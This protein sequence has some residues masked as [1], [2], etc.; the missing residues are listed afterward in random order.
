[1]GDNIFRTRKI[2]ILG[3]KPYRKLQQIKRLDFTEKLMK[4]GLTDTSILLHDFG[5]SY[6]DFLYMQEIEM[7]GNGTTGKSN[8]LEKYFQNPL[9]EVRHWRIIYKEQE[10][11]ARYPES[12]ERICYDKCDLGYP[13]LGCNRRHYAWHT[14]DYRQQNR[15]S[16]RLRSQYSISGH[17]DNSLYTRIREEGSKDVEKGA[18][19]LYTDIE[20]G[21]V[22]AKIKT[23]T[24]RFEGMFLWQPMK[25]GL[26]SFVPDESKEPFW[27][28]DSGFEKYGG[29]SD[30]TKKV[31][32]IYGWDVYELTDAENKKYWREGKGHYPDKT[33]CV[34]EEGENF[35]TASPIFHPRTL[36]RATDY[37]RQ[38]A[39]KPVSMLLT[40]EQLKAL[41]E[42][43]WVWIEVLEPFPC[44]E[45]VSA[46]YRKGYDYSHGRSFCCG[47]PGMSFLFDYSSYNDAW[48]AY[49]CQP[50]E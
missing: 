36:Q 28:D 4:Q 20:T 8:F 1:M 43:E 15:E 29:M 10:I 31:K 19:N 40:V 14:V 50:K 49:S 47:Y 34:F 5:F 30:A 13:L 2:S 33:F 24:D 32:T 12:R 35:S 9:T 7:Q 48:L 26:F 41:Q 22:Y 16:D 6:C 37:C 45:K 39:R 25:K 23:G 11:R 21:K 38:Y 42:D 44:K 3:V 46:Y 18:K 27:L 17:S